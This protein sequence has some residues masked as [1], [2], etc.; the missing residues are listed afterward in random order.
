[1]DI[2]NN[3]YDNVS[4]KIVFFIDKDVDVIFMNE[5][6]F[7]LISIQLDRIINIGSF[8]YNASVGL[9]NNKVDASFFG[10]KIC[11]D[12]SLTNGDVRS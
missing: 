6:T 2:L 4:K 7:L 1:M 10:I 9:L 3:F 8:A 12:N 11:I 5:T